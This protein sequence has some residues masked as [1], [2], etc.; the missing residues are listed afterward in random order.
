MERTCLCWEEILKV[1]DSIN[2][3]A[4]YADDIY[5]LIG[6]NDGMHWV[7]RKSIQDYSFSFDSSKVLWIEKVNHYFCSSCESR[8]IYIYKLNDSHDL[9]KKI[10]FD[11]PISQMVPFQSS[12]ALATTSCTIYLLSS[13]FELS[14]FYEPLNPNN[15]LVQLNSC[16]G[17]VI[18]STM[19][20]S[21]IISSGQAFPIGKKERNAPYSACMVDEDIIFASSPTGDLWEANSQ[22]VVLKNRSYKSKTGQ[23]VKFTLWFPV[24]SKYVLSLDGDEKSLILLGIDQKSIVCKEISVGRLWFNW[25]EKK[26]FQL[27]ED[28]IQILKIY[29]NIE[30]LQR[31]ISLKDAENSIKLLMKDNSLHKLENLQD[32][33]KL[34]FIERVSIG[35][36]F[37]DYFTSLIGQ[38]EDEN[39][40]LKID[41]KIEENY[42]ENINEFEELSKDIK[43]PK[44]TV[45]E[46]R[47]KRKGRNILSLLWEAFFVWKPLKGKDRI[48]VIKFLSVKVYVSMIVKNDL[49][50]LIS[51]KYDGLEKIRRMKSIAYD[52]YDKIKYRL[53]SI[54]E[55]NYIQRISQIL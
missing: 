25:Q 43:I 12:L 42:D 55:Y 48:R 36:E 9:I 10:I 51:K 30:Y 15:E 22:G 49:L 14:K 47:P 53:I 27:N 28:S 20:R 13:N 7:F 2:I 32:L 26:L 23:K 17:I 40:I 1:D 44:E 8:N 5:T 33:C 34:V 3:S 46:V 19:T 29:T 31:L 54:E 35:Q 11:N 6:R 39:F 16:N 50:I 18:V 4:F 21:I 45:V 41:Q 38:L 24:D 52:S 37:F